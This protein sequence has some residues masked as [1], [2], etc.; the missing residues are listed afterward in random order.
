MI[1]IGKVMNSK[2][3]YEELILKDRRWFFVFIILSVA[4]PMLSITG[5]IKPENESIG[6]WFSRSGSTVVVFALYAE[7]RAVRML[8]V[9]N[10]G[11]MVD[12]THEATRRKYFFQIRCF[13]ILA[14]SLIVIGTIIWGYGDIVFNLVR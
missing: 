8:S 4:L 12:L 13:N 14:L 2:C 6:D 10:Q 11:G 1:G 7:A 3:I 5:V 9:I